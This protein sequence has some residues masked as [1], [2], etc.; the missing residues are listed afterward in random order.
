MITVRRPPPSSAR[1]R[2]R[3]MAATW[4]AVHDPDW[5]GSRKCGTKAVDPAVECEGQTYE[6]AVDVSF[7]ADLPNGP[8]AI[9]DFTPPHAI[10]FG[11]Q[12]VFIPTSGAT[13]NDV[14]KPMMGKLRERI[15]AWFQPLKAKVDA[16]NRA[17][18]TSIR[19]SYGGGG[20]KQIAY[21]IE[22][23]LVK[24]EFKGGGVS[25]EGAAR[26]GIHSATIQTHITKS[27]E[28]FTGHGD[29]MSMPD[30]SDASMSGSGCC[31]L[32]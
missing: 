27:C 29:T 30:K 19:S 25:A 17:N 32:Q 21:Q 23:Y 8:Y 6:F 31:I 11:T 5:L 28:G 20:G 13:Y 9:P 24:L 10:H 4:V 1:L 15:D 14:V 22:V 12:K 16:S 26:E 2:S 3:A 7:D 18:A